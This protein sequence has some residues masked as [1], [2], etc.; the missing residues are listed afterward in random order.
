MKIK[1]GEF[2]DII[3]EIKTLQ[4]T[5]KKIESLTEESGEKIVISLEKI[6]IA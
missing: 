2:Q 6:M 3:E 1:Q 4:N 5:S